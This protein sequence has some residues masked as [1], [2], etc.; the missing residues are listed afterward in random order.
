MADFGT[1]EQMAASMQQMQQQ[2]QHMQELQQTIAAQQLAAQREPPVPIGTTDAAAET[3]TSEE[4]QQEVSYVNEQGWQFKN[5]H[6][7]PNVRNNPHLFSYKT[8]PNNPNDRSQGNQFQNTG[9]QKPYL[10]NQ[11]QNGKMLILSQ[12]HNQFQNRQ[13][14][15][16][17]APATASGKGKQKEGEQPPLEDVH[18][19]DHEPEQPTAVEPVAPTTQHQPVPTRVY[20][21]KVPY[22][23]PAKKSRKDCE[24]MKCKKMLDELN[25]KFSLM[26]AIQMIPSM[27][28][29][30][31]HTTFQMMAPRRTKAAS[32]IKPSYARGEPEDYT[33]PPTYPWPREEGTEISLTDPNIPKSSETRW[34]K[35]ASRRYNTLLNTDIFPTRFVDVGALSD[36]GLHEDLHAVLQV[37]GISDLCHK[38]HPLYPDL[39]SISLETLTEIYEIS[40][41]YTQTSF[42][43]KFIPEQAFWKF[44]ASGDFKSRSASQSYIRKI[45]NVLCTVVNDW[46]IDVFGLN[47][48]QWNEC[49]GLEKECI[50][51]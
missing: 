3:E 29:L 11:N 21:P 32:R 19:D 39:P 28:S 42:P 15:P 10:Q 25:V 47:F 37:L 9:N 30:D 40:E 26:D 16:H 50:V 34:D 45:Q 22:P 51:F 6:P 46:E 49:I 8:N 1:L 31:S 41:E 48:E 5:Y 43:R 36:L 14:N 13:N 27:H 7:N 17:A 12:A 35:E 2:M 4:D 38:T 20:I 44:I 24:D 23:V 18:D 33:V